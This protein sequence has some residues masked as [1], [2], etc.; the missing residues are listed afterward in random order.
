MSIAFASSKTL[1]RTVSNPSSSSTVIELVP[2]TIVPIESGFK[3]CNNLRKPLSADVRSKM[4]GKYPYYGP[5]GIL[6]YLNEY[7]V[8]GTY[9]LIGEDGDHF[10]KYDTW[11]MT[12]LIHEKSNVNNHAHLLQG[13]NGN[14]TEWFYFYFKH[15]SI[16]NFLSK[17]GSGRMKLNKTTLQ[18]MNILLPSPKMQRELC[19]KYFEIEKTLEKEQENIINANEMLKQLL[20]SYL[21]G[22]N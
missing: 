19:R 13:K 1:R 6:D 7:R 16:L 3:I 5:T 20:Q 8:D 21:G 14:L 12:Q 18:C 4:Q 15:R 17:Q 10:L 9:T 11:N 22:A 2:I